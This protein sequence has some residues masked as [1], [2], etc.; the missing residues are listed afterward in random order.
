ML[1]EKSGEEK[2]RERKRSLQ[3]NSSQCRKLT[4]LFGNDDDKWG[5]FVEKGQVAVAVAVAV[6]A[7]GFHKGQS[8]E[9]EGQTVPST[10]RKKVALVVIRKKNQSL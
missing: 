8:C 3:N 10:S 1:K 4:E 6:K 2:C 5:V 7:D 9:R